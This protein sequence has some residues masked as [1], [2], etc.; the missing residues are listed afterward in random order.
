MPRFYMSGVEHEGVFPVLVTDQ[1]RG[2]RDG[3]GGPPAALPAGVSDRPRARQLQEY[4]GVRAHGR[5]AAG[6]DQP[7]TR[8]ALR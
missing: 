4:G 8:L 3:G 6:W 1:G 5:P 7:A 2:R